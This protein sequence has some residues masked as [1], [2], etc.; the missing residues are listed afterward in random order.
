MV[1]AEAG[2]TAAT[3]DRWEDAGSV[4]RN[5]THETRREVQVNVSVA[6]EQ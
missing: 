2:A 3:P 5:A 1:A 6:G 4:L